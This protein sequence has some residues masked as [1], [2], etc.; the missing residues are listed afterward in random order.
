MKHALPLFLILVCSLLTPCSGVKIDGDDGG[1]KRADLCVNISMDNMRNIYRGERVQVNYSIKCL[2]NRATDIT[3]KI[4]I[5]SCFSS[6]KLI[7]TPN[8]FKN[9]YKYDDEITFKE[10]QLPEDGCETCSY[11]AY[12]PKNAPIKEY[13]LD[14]GINKR[15]WSW[16]HRGDLIVNGKNVLCVHNNVPEISFC[17]VTAKPASFHGLF[18][19]SA[20]PPNSS[21]NL[22]IYKNTSVSFNCIA[23]DIEDEDLTY[24]W[25]DNQSKIGSS[26]NFTTILHPGVHKNFRVVVSDQDGDFQETNIHKVVE[27]YSK[28]MAEVH[29]EYYN[30]MMFYASVLILVLILIF[31]LIKNVF[32]SLSC[33]LGFMLIT[34]LA[35]YMTLTQISKELASLV[36]IIELFLLTIMMPCASYFI[37]SSLPPSKKCGSNRHSAINKVCSDFKSYYV[38]YIT[39]AI[40]F[41]V[42]GMIIWVIPK[43]SDL[44]DLNMDVKCNY[45]FW[46]Y[47]MMT[48]TFGAI[49]AIIAMV[50]TSQ[51]GKSFLD[52]KK[53]KNF[54]VL[55][56]SI[57]LSSILGLVTRTVPPLEPG[58]LN[59]FLD[60]IPL[61]FFEVS[62]LLA[63]PAIICLGELIIDFAK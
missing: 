61:F 28:D 11:Y 63:V 49:L 1:V 34:V 42:V 9:I 26:P 44:S 24:E 35:Y 10:E 50:A 13:K 46:Y 53:I 39:M 15:S 30:K 45:I 18:R 2:N 12:I 20:N 19:D 32:R 22:T 60:V 4:Q 41:I 47:S 59:N 40:M 6:S 25:Y 62:L 52:V 17:N 43:L 33:V 16:S 14:G 48:Q 27:V 5:P 56:I 3:G 55:Y 36:G 31:T 37:T 51:R 57:I 7:S 21:N 58:I 8:S 54:V 23:F 38:W 29:Q